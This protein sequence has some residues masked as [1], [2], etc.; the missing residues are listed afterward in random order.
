[1]S[2]TVPGE[3]RESFIFKYTSSY[4]L[5]VKPAGS[6]YLILKHV[7]LH[8]QETALSNYCSHKLFYNIYV[9]VIPRLPFCFPSGNFTA[10]FPTEIKLT[11]S[12][13][14]GFHYHVSIS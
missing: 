12:Q 4:F 6:T 1:M 13:P 2:V 10:S 5:A 11:S 3:R 8:G 9:N 14:P 7:I